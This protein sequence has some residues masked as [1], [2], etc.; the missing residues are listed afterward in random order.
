MTRASK[1]YFF[2]EESVEE[3]CQ[4]VGEF[5]GLYLDQQEASNGPLGRRVVP[6]MM[7]VDRAVALTTQLA[8][9]FEE[10]DVIPAGLTAVRFREPVLYDEPVEIE[11]EKV[12]E[13]KLCYIDFEAFATE[14][15]SVLTTHGTISTLI[16]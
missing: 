15:N 5:N 10:E 3:Y 4:G 2:D 9:S 11:V 16:T 12:S 13:D 7:V 8:E 1:T 6:Q 14:R